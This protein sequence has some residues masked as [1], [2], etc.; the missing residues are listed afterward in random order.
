MKNK[1]GK[2]VKRTNKEIAKFN[3]ITKK[4]IHQNTIEW[5]IWKTIADKTDNTTGRNISKYNGTRR[6]TQKISGVGQTRKKNRIFQ[7][8]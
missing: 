5:K 8:N 1:T 2:E 6:E 4:K 7:S 3:E